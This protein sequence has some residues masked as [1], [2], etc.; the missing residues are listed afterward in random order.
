MRDARGDLPDRVEPLQLLN[1]GFG[2]LP[3]LDLGAQLPIGLLQLTRA[4]L[5]AALERFFDTLAIGHIERH[6]VK[7]D[8]LLVL[9]MCLTTRRDPAFHA[10]R[11]SDHAVLDIVHAVAPR[12]GAVLDRSLDARKILRMHT[13]KPRRVVHRR[14]RRQAPHGP[15]RVVPFQLVGFWVP[16]IKAELHEIYRGLQ[17]GL[18]FA[19]P[20][21]GALALVDIFENRDPAGDLAVL[22]TKRRGADPEP[23]LLSVIRATKKIETR[24]G[25]FSAQR[26]APGY[27]SGKAVCRR[28]RSPANARSIPDRAMG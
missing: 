22:V 4:R 1:R 25:G 6:P 21:A 23:G 19:Q 28:H 17:P 11:L 9:E 18:A 8:G 3:L 12:V 15:Q 16:R 13:G 10:V 7:R 5:D 26:R 24:G 27:A 14:V 20:L 2:E